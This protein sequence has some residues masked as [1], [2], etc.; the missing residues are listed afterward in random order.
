M[1]ATFNDVADEAPIETVEIIGEG[2]MI[3]KEQTVTIETSSVDP[4]AAWNFWKY[5]AIFTG[6]GLCL[7]LL[8]SK[9]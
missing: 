5:A 2:T 6:I 4:E 3:E 7:F 1:E 9:N 8:G